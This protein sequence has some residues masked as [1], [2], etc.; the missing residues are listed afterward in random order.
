MSGKEREI[1]V[2]ENPQRR[3]DRSKNTEKDVNVNVY[4]L[5]G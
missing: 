1:V 5:D 4:R 3:W 2:Y